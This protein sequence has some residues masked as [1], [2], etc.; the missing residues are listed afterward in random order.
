MPCACV[1]SKFKNYFTPET[2]RGQ[3]KRGGGDFLFLFFS[4]TSRENSLSLW[5]MLKFSAL[6][7]FWF[8][9][10]C[11]PC[12]G[13]CNLLFPPTTSSPTLF[14][15]FTHLSTMPAQIINLKGEGWDAGFLARGI[16]ST[17]QM[18]VILN[19]YKLIPHLPKP[20]QKIVLSTR[21]F[22][23]HNYLQITPLGQLTL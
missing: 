6:K 12:C 2:R 16:I 15:Q 10:A 7:I 23:K 18:R 9:I 3:R 11:C 5:P 17:R 22:V 13:L 1:G 19:F 8:T 4:F 14:L 20:A 21:P